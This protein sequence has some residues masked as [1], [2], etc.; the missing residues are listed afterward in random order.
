MNSIYL[1]KHALE[2]AL[3]EPQIPQNCG[4]I[5][6]TCS[7]SQTPLKLCGKLGFSLDER[8]YK[9]AGLDYHDSLC[10]SHEE[11]LEA[12]LDMYWERC[13]FFSSQ[14]TTSLWDGQFQ[15][16]SILVFGS[17]PSGFPKQLWQRFESEQEKQKKLLRIPMRKSSEARCINLATSVGICLYEAMRKVTQLAS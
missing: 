2:V 7:V 5:A 16:N 13:I 3:I 17:E 1:P 9:R 12:W 6:R 14:A 8:H 10:L 15:T 11:D 4:N